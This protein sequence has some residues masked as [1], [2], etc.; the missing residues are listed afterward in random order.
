VPVLDGV[1]S[2]NDRDGNHAVDFIASEAWENLDATSANLHT[3]I[4]E[5]ISRYAFVIASISRMIAHIFTADQIARATRDRINTQLI[6]NL[7]KVEP[8]FYCSNDASRLLKMYVFAFW[9]KLATSKARV[10]LIPLFI[11]SM[12]SFFLWASKLIPV[13][14]LHIQ[15]L[16]GLKSGAYFSCVEEHSLL[17]FRMVS[18]P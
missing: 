15:E 8:L 3:Y 1:I 9:L 11:K 4:D 7:I 14:I 10:T 2:F 16:R 13:L 12:Y 17:L 5:R 6:Q 18:Q